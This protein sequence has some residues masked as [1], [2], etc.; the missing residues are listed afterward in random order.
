MAIEYAVVID[1]AEVQVEVGALSQRLEEA[2]AESAGVWRERLESGVVLLEEGLSYREAMALQRQLGQRSIP[3]QVKEAQAVSAEPVEATVAGTAEED[4]GAWGELFPDLE[5]TAEDEADEASA[6]VSDGDLGWEEVDLDMPVIDDGGV[7]GEALE[8]SELE[9]W[10]VDGPLPIVE[11]MDDDSDEV[12]EESG[13]EATF[14]GMRIHE[15]LGSGERRPFEPRGYDPR[16]DHVPGVAAMWSAIAPGAGQIYNGQE[17]KAQRYGLLFFLIQPWVKAVTQAQNYGEKIRDYHAPRPPAG[18]WKKSLAYALKWWVSVGII[19]VMISLVVDLVAEYRQKEAEHHHALMARQ[20]IYHSQ[21]VVEVAV[22]RGAQAADRAPL[23]DDEDGA[24][25]VEPSYTM[26]EEERAQRL[27]IIG[28]HYCRG[29]NYE[30]CEQLMGRVTSAAPGNRDA[31]RLQ[32]W[33]SMQARGNWEDRPMPEIEG[34]VPT[35][36]E[37]EIQLASEGREVDDYDEE[38]DVWWNARGRE[39]VEEEESREFEEVDDEEA[40]EALEEQGD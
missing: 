37:F 19:A 40:L 1:M 38:F 4:K 2:T 7:D 18:Q 16:P 3:S 23:P 28:Y 26:E 27:F 14:D 15:A 20:L 33:A 29:G 35:L 8:D 5:A 13:G 24:D 34:E 6:L 22:R 30:M 32:A 31:F 25:E 36:E 21:D 39:A 10:A 12:D 17:E 11:E 9:E